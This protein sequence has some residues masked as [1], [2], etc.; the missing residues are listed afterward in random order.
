LGKSG[1]KQKY[2]FLGWTSSY[3]YGMPGM[4]TTSAHST[5]SGLKGERVKKREDCCC[6]AAALVSLL[7]L[8]QWNQPLISW[9]STSKGH[10]YR[11][12]TVR[13]VPSP[14][15]LGTGEIMI[16][17]EA[18]ND[19]HASQL[20]FAGSQTA[21]AKNQTSRNAK[22]ADKAPKPIKAT[23]CVVFSSDLIGDASM[24]EAIQTSFVH[25]SMRSEVDAGEKFNFYSSPCDTVTSIRWTKQDLRSVSPSEVQHFEPYILQVLDNDIFI[26]LVLKSVNGFEFPQLGFHLEQ[27]FQPHIRA[28]QRS[29]MADSD[30][31]DSA[32]AS[33]RS[34]CTE[35]PVTKV[36]ALINLEPVIL[37]AQRR[38]SFLSCFIAPY[39]HCYL[40][41]ALCTYS[42]SPFTAQLSKTPNENR[43]ISELV[44]CAT[45]FLLYEHKIEVT[46]CKKLVEFSE[47]LQTLTRL[48]DQRDYEQH[49]TELDFVMK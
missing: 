24:N 36:M 32:D 34:Y 29:R 40:C 18:S 15:H 35:V 44:D 33:S 8:P 22:R 27:L 20:Q 28:Y 43:P 47:Y 38:V 39:C 19:S 16:V 31:N 5:A 3:A 30:A 4:V 12:R 45:S 41:F 42:S 11:C 23:A 10:E 17:D 26:D 37:K 1:S 6:C 48:I 13:K 2:R 7:P 49:A 21:A 9:T 14:A 25:Y 46:R